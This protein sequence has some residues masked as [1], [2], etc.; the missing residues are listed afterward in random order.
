MSRN[1][2]ADGPEAAQELRPGRDAGDAGAVRRRGRGA[3]ADRPPH[4]GA[5]ARRAGRL[6]R[7]PRGRRGRHRGGA[8]I[9]KGREKAE[10]HHQKFAERI[11]KALKDGTAPWQKPWQPGERILPHNFGSGRDYRGGCESAT[12]MRTRADAPR[13]N[14]PD[15]SGEVLAAVFGMFSARWSCV[16]RAVCIPRHSVGEIARWDMIAESRHGRS[17]LQQ[18][19]SLAAAD[20]A[21]PPGRLGVPDAA[22]GQLRQPR[23]APAPQRLGA[24]V[25]YSR[26]VPGTMRLRPHETNS[27]KTAVWRPGIDWKGVASRSRLVRRLC[28]DSKRGERPDDYVR[29]GEADGQHVR[30]STKP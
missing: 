6:G 16:A 26:V 5:V 13:M 2:K 3:A 17:C 23:P 10:D 25:R 18:L 11:I 14:I 15:G 27:S 24:C 7:R 8:V 9:A 1:N 19:F 12:V 30:A 20:G 21:K 4:R 29:S 28:D 22:A